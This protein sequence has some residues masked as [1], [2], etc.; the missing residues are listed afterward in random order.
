MLGFIQY[1]LT[2]V[3]EIMTIIFLNSQTSYLFILLFYAALAGVTTFDNMYANA[4]PIDHSIKKAVG[5]VFYQTFHRFM[6]YKTERDGVE[7]ALNVEEKIEG[8]PHK[9]NLG[10]KSMVLVDNPRSGKCLFMLG[11]IIYK[12]FRI[13]HVSFFFYFAPFLMLVY[14]FYLNTKNSNEK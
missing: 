5:K 4:L 11:R 9:I 12:F 10:N 6:K 8:E 13:V 3:L 1:A 2:I 7:A 14:Q